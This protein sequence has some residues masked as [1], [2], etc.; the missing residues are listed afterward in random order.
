MND[1]HKL[2]WGTNEVEHLFKQIKLSDNLNHKNILEI[3]EKMLHTLKLTVS[4]I[5]VME[6]DL[7]RKGL[8]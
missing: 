6:S 2:K 4:Y 3:Q 1:I 7:K 5:E 8:L